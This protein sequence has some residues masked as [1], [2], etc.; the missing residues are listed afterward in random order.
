MTRPQ[1]TDSRS[2]RTAPALIDWWLFGAALLLLCFGLVMVSSASMTV[3]DRLAGDPFFYVYRHLFALALGVTG[4]L[5]F[6]QISMAQWQRV[7][8]LLVFFGLMLL[9]LLLVPGVGR[10]VNGAT[11]WI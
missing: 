8:P 7:G 2:E 11:R 3:G 4:G 1:A 9:L 5:V 6:F 10:T